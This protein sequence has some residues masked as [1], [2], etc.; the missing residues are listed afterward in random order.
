MLDNRLARSSELRVT[1]SIVTSVEKQPELINPALLLKQAWARILWRC[2]GGPVGRLLCFDAINRVYAETLAREDALDG[3]CYFEVCLQCLGVRVEVSED[4]LARIPAHG[5]LIT[6][7]N[8]PFGGL[9]GLALGAILA[10]RRSDFKLLVNQLLAGIEPMKNHTIAVDVFGGKGAALTNFGPLRES[11]RL[12]KSGGVLGLFPS[13]TV[14]HFNLRRR[15]ILDPVWAPNLAGIIRRSGAKVIP[16]YFEGGNSRFFQAMGLLHPALRTAFLGRELIHPTTDVI[17]LRVGNPISTTHLTRFEDDASLMSFLRIKTYIL[18]NRKVAEKVSFRTRRWRRNASVDARKPIASPIDPALLQAE[19]DRLPK[20]RCLVQ[21]GE[22]RVFFAR[23]EEIPQ[24]LQEI[25]IRRE[26]TFRAVG[27]GTGLAL[28]LDRF[29]RS[30]IH[31][32]LWNQLTNE[33]VG[34]YRLG[35]TDE[36]LAQ[37]GPSGLYTTTL[38]R[39]RPGILDRL[40]PAL[41]L[42][43]SFVVEAYQRKHASLGLIWQ[44]I[45]QFVVRFPRYRMLFGPVS[46]SNEYQGLSKDLIVTYLK[47]NA[48]DP[49]LSAQVKAR[50]PPRAR[51]RGRLDRRSFSSNMRDIEDVSAL[52]SD[53]EREE[54]GVPMLLR[55]YLKLNATMLSFNV[56]PGFSDCI[57]GL[58][59]VDLL[60]AK[61][62]TLR[63]YMGNEGFEIFHA[64]HRSV[65]PKSSGSGAI[66]KAVV[67]A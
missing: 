41:E 31:L 22:Y 55:Q 19:I 43:R 18:Q 47:E 12:L 50:K 29:D 51:F 7:S 11:L 24:L 16:I 56:D 17:R 9:D 33:L 3:G 13:G 63:R 62:K 40:S 44:G 52:I 49:D 38:F 59:L 26:L 64:Y 67:E 30:Y 35:L 20:E 57:D 1:S 6:V 45:G 8:H 60:K 53:I 4:D 54:R 65:M 37:E 14:S 28:D 25:G 36:I 32:F 61:E 5:P 10:R 23:A 2:F 27:E 34:A 66:E 39:Y 48:L 46:I 58:V 21:H 15:Q 42:G